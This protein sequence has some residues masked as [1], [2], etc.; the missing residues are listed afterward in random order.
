MV[1]KFGK[2]IGAEHVLADE[3]ETAG[4]PLT[5]PTAADGPEACTGCGINT[6][7]DGK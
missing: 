2:A 7:S 6:G 4:D 5:L 3:E 1:D